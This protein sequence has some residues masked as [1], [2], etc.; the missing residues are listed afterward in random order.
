MRPLS[1]GR[2]PVSFS[3]RGARYFLQG[4]ERTRTADLISLRV[5]GHALQGFAKG[6]KCRIDRR[7]SAPDCPVLHR[8]VLPVVSE[9]YHEKSGDSG[10][11][12]AGFFA[13]Q[14]CQML[15]GPPNRRGEAPTRDLNLRLCF[16]SPFT[17]ADIHAGLTHVVLTTMR[18]TGDYGRF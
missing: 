1:D 14:M 17:R 16:P 12:V 3:S 15:G 13:I 9:W 18:R 7:L 11:R 2:G 8:I 5:I 10:L 4:D 6:C